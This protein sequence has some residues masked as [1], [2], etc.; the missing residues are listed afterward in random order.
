[1]HFVHDTENL[2]QLIL[3]GGDKISWSKSAVAKR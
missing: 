2:S 1:V 3:F